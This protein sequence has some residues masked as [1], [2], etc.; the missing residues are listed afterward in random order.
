MFEDQIPSVREQERAAEERQQQGKCR[1]CGEVGDGSICARC[2]D[3]RDNKDPIELPEWAQGV[4]T[5][6]RIY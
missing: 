6:E 1:G 3:G 5:F 4:M 2:W